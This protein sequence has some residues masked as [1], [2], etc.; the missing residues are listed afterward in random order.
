V[1]ASRK[2][3]SVFDPIYASATE[4][5]RAIREGE[6]SAVAVL[7]AHLERI[8]CLNGTIHAIV[9]LD[10]AGARARAQAADEA[11]ARGELWGPLHGVPITLHDHCEVIGMRSTVM[12]NPEY[13]DHVPTKEPNVIMRLRAAGAIFVGRTNDD[14]GFFDEARLFPLPVH[15]WDATR[16]LTGVGAP[17]SAVA[18]GLTS[19]EL[20]GDAGS[21]QMP[22]H[23]T[24]V[25]AFRPTKHRLP[26]ADFF[27]MNPVD[28]IFNVGNLAPIA[29]TIEDLRLA[30]E[31]I[32]GPDGL[33]T[34][35]PP[36]PLDEYAAPAL[37]G[38]RIAW[39]S[40]I[41]GA[42]M[43]D[44]IAAGIEAL[45][46][47]LQGEGVYMEQQLPDSDFTQMLALFDKLLFMPIEA[48]NSIN[49]ADPGPS[50]GAFMQVWHE[51]NQIW[52]VWDAFLGEWDALL[53]PVV[54]MVAPVR[55]A[56]E[57]VVNG[58]VLTAEERASAYIPSK[59][60]PVTGLPTVIM[61]L[62]RTREGLPYGV[63]L[64][65]RR[66]QDMGLLAIAE[67][68]AEVAGGFVRPPDY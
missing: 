56:T 35:V 65:G 60:A 63:Q 9:T 49:T 62:G 14:H 31:V 12:G 58:V 43:D 39:A 53:A 44:E 2:T 51:Q 47:R 24:G 28:Y 66:W 26:M 15:P 38:L 55:G 57:R 25:F 34:H 13:A 7:E 27:F 21:T 33:D 17:A 30:M 42:V 1:R 37:D 54:G 22:A 8:A 16:A 46:E 5:A 11:L 29:R 48:V 40:R 61:P 45:A 36:L 52:R 59:I 23:F 32:A 68:V 64:L 4:I 10:E 18:T 67:Q 19:L 41:P 20:A 3:T 6:T 50:L